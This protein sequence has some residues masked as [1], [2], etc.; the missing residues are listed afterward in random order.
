MHLLSRLTFV[1]GHK[2]NLSFT[3]P[4]S[5]NTHIV[6]L[7]CYLYFSFLL[8]TAFYHSFLHSPFPLLPFSYFLILFSPPSSSSSSSNQSHASREQAGKFDN[9]LTDHAAGSVSIN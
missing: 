7:F 1:V 4:Y 8:L 5:R 9:K 2:V 6:L 3:I